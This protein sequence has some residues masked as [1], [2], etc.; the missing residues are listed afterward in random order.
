MSCHVMSCH[1]MSCHVAIVVSILKNTFQKLFH[2]TKL[3]INILQASLL[4]LSRHYEAIY[5]R[6]NPNR[7]KCFFWQQ[8]AVAPCVNNPKKSAKW[9]LHT[10]GFLTGRRAKPHCYESWIAS[11]WKCSQWQFSKSRN[12]DFKVVDKFIKFVII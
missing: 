9:K 5:S 6:S 8:G 2:F 11:H 3:F 7:E 1:V 12:N 4:A 10:M